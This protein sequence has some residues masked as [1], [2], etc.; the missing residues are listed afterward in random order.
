MN[1]V[2]LGRCKRFVQYLWD[3]EPRNDEEPDTSIWC[4]GKEYTPSDAALTWRDQPSTFKF[5][6]HYPCSQLP[7]PPMPNEDDQREPSETGESSSSHGWPESFLND[8][9]S[10]VWI[11]YRSNFPP[12]PRHDGRGGSRSMALGVR[13]RTQFMDSQGFTSDTG[14]GCMIRSGQSL[15]ANALSTLILGRGM[16]STPLLQHGAVA[17]TR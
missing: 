14:W 9:E 2:D 15:L 12:I 16:P 13:L 6:L 5:K 17:K 1:S 4:L 10:R 7:E 3:P 8:F 11:T